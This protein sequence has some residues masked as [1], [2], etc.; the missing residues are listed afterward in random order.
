MIINGTE[1][2]P[3]KSAIVKIKVGDLPSGTSINLFAHVYRSKHP[4]PTMLVLGGIHGDEINGVEIVRRSVKAGLFKKLNIGSVIAVPLLNIYGFINFSRDLPDGKD[5]NRS[6]PGSSRGSLASKVAFTLSKHI[7]PLVDFGMDFHTGG[8]SIHNYPQLRVSPNDKMSLKLAKA[9]SPPFIVESK[10]IGGSLRKECNKRGIPMVV[11]EG[12]ES[13]RLDS[14]SV[15]EGINGIK[16][17]MFSKGMISE[18]SPV[19]KS[20]VIK[21]SRWIRATQSGLFIAYKKS[22]DYVD[23]GEVLGHLTDPY[24]NKESRV[25]SPVSGIIYGHNNIPLIN[26]GD[27]LFHIGFE[28]SEAL[29]FELD[30]E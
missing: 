25:K 18:E 24:G 5:V 7:L 2:L 26:L 21:N 10:L 3:G 23:K 30:D 16:R 12:G 29:N 22:G 28:D 4:G 19:Q 9:F 17:V 27:A 13:L 15:Q 11:Y 14:F 1:I 8:R 6:F 20:I